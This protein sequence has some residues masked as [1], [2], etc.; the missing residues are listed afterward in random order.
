MFIVVLVIAYQR[1]N[2]FSII[3]LM[4]T[5]VTGT[6]SLAIIFVVGWIFGVL[7]SSS[8]V[9]EQSPSRAFQVIFIVI[10]SLHGIL[11]FLFEIYLSKD[12]Q[13]MWIK[14]YYYITCRPH[15]Y[16]QQHTSAQ[17]YASHFSTSTPK[18]SIKT[19]P[20]TGKVTKL[21]HKP[22][23]QSGLV[24]HFGKGNY[25][26]DFDNPVALATFHGPKTTTGTGSVQLMGEGTIPREENFC[27]VYS[28]FEADDD[29][30]LELPSLSPLTDQSSSPSER[31]QPIRPIAQSVTDVEPL[32]D[33]YFSLSAEVND[34]V[35]S[36]LF[37]QDQPWPPHEQSISYSSFMPLAQTPHEMNGSEE[38]TD[39]AIEQL[40]PPV[41]E[42]L[43]LRRLNL[44]RP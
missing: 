22:V 1:R 18:P 36:P 28:G 26:T 25:E 13:K 8:V 38:A 43:Q 23:P 7:G 21:N 30:E 14:C 44:S 15:L 39:T 42:H 6:F 41:A 29:Q 12:A 4:V 11:I 34:S 16:Y 9:E 5:T 40:P 33:F 35:S 10:I 37:I 2:R 20:E 17:S 32:S 19:S 3:K 24:S 31:L 27:A